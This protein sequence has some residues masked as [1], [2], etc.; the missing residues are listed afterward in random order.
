[1]PRIAIKDLPADKQFE[2]KF[3]SYVFGGVQFMEWH[4]PNR[5]LYQLDPRTGVLT[6][7]DGSYGRRPQEGADIKADYRD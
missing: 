7:S 3:I 4:S 5:R 1:M 6:L 2:E